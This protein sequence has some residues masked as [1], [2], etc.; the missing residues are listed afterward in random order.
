MAFHHLHDFLKMG[1]Y[2]QF[3]WLAYGIVFVVMMINILLP[4]RRHQRYQIKRKRM[5]QW[6]K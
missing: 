1:G 2:A 4:W 6:E 3:V 5:N